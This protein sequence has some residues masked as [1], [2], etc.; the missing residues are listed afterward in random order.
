MRIWKGKYTVSLIPGDGKDLVQ[1]CLQL[2]TQ[3][4]LLFQV[5][6]LRLASLSKRYITL[7]R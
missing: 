7:L 4:L 6:G 5:S 1:Q 2:L 3:W